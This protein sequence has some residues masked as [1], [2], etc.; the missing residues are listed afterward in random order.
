MMSPQ[1]VLIIFSFAA[2]HI[3]LLPYS[4]RSL[5]EDKIENS[6]GGPPNFIDNKIKMY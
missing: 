5:P 4:Q 1:V 3:L 6:A 2:P